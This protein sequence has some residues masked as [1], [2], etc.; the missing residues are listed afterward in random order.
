VELLGVTLVARIHWGTFPLLAG[1]P[2]ALHDAMR[3]RGL[4]ATIHAWKPGDTIS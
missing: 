3:A 4:G 2:E 1:T